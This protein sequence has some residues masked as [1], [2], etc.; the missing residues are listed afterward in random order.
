[1][2][3]LSKL[4]HARRN[5]PVGFVLRAGQYVV[6]Q[7]LRCITGSHLQMA[8]YSTRAESMI[9]DLYQGFMRQFGF[10]AVAQV[11]HTSD[12]LETDNVC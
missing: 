9:I 7:F 4:K 8:C 11:L 10:C 5:Q 1:M 6:I 2:R 3:V 12:F